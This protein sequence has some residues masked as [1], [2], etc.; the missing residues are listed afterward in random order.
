MVCMHV[1]TFKYRTHQFYVAFS[2]PYS[3]IVKYLYTNNDTNNKQIQLVGCC[4]WESCWEWDRL[5]AAVQL[6]HS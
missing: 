2:T 4:T 3:R 6:N 5:L 1:H